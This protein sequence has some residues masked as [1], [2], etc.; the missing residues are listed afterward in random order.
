MRVF[1]A[2]DM[3]MM[4]MTSLYL[5]PTRFSHLLILDLFKLGPEFGA[6]LEFFARLTRLDRSVRVLERLKEA[7]LLILLLHLGKFLLE[8][9]GLFEFERKFKIVE[10]GELVL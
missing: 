9:L 8:Q 2:G 5:A 7:F 3:M 1:I 4:V 6:L 10:G